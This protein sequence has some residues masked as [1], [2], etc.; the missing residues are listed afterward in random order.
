MSYILDAL[1]KSDQL[2]RR[3]AAPTL[4]LG[5]VPEAAPKQAPL[6]LYGLLALV[7]LAAGIAI[8]W[9]HPWQ[10]EATVPTQLADAAKR[11]ELRQRPTPAVQQPG[12]APKA[13]LPTQTSASAGPAPV[14]VPASAATPVSVQAH[15]SAA[16]VAK[17]NTPRKA[18]AKA[19]ES[20]ATPVPVPETMPGKGGA[21]GAT[22]P[23]AVVMTMAELPVAIQQELPA[24]SISVHAYSGKAADRLVDINGHLL[25][26]G[27]S[28]AP[29]L[30]LDQITPDGMILSYKGYTFRRG[31]H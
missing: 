10:R 9:L 13:E 5:P 1:R 14:P 29:G 25:H 7:L 11:P 22:L 18:V 20:A 28:V 4:L 17:R 24:M 8:G 3:N 26:E 12:V 31:V 6:F 23:E 21:T 15:G 27:E 16:A 30:T 19:R 2:R